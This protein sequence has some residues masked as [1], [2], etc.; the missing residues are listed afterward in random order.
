MSG[1][2]GLLGV[3]KPETMHA[4]GEQL[5]DVL[6]FKEDGTGFLDY[7]SPSTEYVNE[8]LRWSS[9]APGELRLRGERLRRFTADRTGIIEQPST[10]DAIVSFSIRTEHTSAGRCTRVLRMGACPW[11]GLSDPSCVATRRYQAHEAAYATFV[12]PCFLLKE[13]AN[14]PT[15]RGKALSGYLA[16][17]LETRQLPVGEMLRVFMGCCYHRDVEV[18][19]QQLGMAVNWDRDLQAWWLR[20]S[21]PPIGGKAEAEELCGILREILERVDGIHDL[22]W[23]TEEEWLQLCAQRGRGSVPGSRT[24]NAGGIGDAE[25][26]GP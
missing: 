12:A 22:A 5:Y 9:S 26:P 20:V 4:S 25:V 18:G 23:H 13:E 21:P 3:W 14:D 17:Q 24:A 6:V 8:E 1:P 2:E 7:S 16:K 11:S 15:F 10:L 19:G